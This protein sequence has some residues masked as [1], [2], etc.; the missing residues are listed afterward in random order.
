MFGGEEFEFA[1][2]GGDDLAFFGFLGAV[3]GVVTA[4]A[5]EFGVGAD[6]GEERG[7]VGDGD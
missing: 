3:V 2:E 4:A 7:D 1:V 6:G 5:V